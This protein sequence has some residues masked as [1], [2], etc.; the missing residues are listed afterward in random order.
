MVLTLV[1]GVLSIKVCK[2]SFFFLK[3]KDNEKMGLH[4]FRG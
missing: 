3:Y 1:S 2:L 4:T